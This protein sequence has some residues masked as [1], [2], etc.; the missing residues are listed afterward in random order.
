MSTLT[1]VPKLSVVIKNIKALSGGI[2]NLDDAITNV[3]NV[4]S[5]SVTYL[6]GLADDYLMELQMMHLAVSNSRSSLTSLFDDYKRQNK[7]YLYILKKK[8]YKQNYA[9]ENTV[10]LRNKFFD[11][12]NSFRSIQLGWAISK[13]V[14]F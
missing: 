7:N 3:D 11:I 8:A 5:S 12:Q 10:A 14:D 6:R 1:Y 2:I 13:M 4:D 9:T